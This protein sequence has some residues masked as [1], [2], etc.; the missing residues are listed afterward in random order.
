[1]KEIY[2]ANQDRGKFP[3]FSWVNPKNYK[4]QNG[5]DWPASKNCLVGYV[6]GAEALRLD[7]LSDDQ[8]K[9]EIEATFSAAF[10]GQIA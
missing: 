4:K 10:P 3:C 9:D 7:S 6:V 8:I 1:V 2:I 5:G